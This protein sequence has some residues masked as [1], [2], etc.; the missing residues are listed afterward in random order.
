MTEANRKVTEILTV[1]DRLKRGLSPSISA[2]LQARRDALAAVRRERP[3]DRTRLAVSSTKVHEFAQMVSKV[4]TAWRFPAAPRHKG[5]VTGLTEGIPRGE[6]SD[7]FWRGY[8]R[9]AISGE[10]A[11]RLFGERASRAR[12]PV[13]GRQPELSSSSLAAVR[14]G[15]D[16]GRRRRSAAWTPDAAR[17]GSSLQ[18]F[19]AGGPSDNPTEGPKPAFG[20]TV[21]SV[22]ADRGGRPGP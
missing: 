2:L 13:E 20:G 21:G 11:R 3:T 16:R 7:S 5:P 18:R 22:C 1:R 9:H 10:I 14:D 17:L 6:I 12:S 15:M 19:G 4:L 8:L